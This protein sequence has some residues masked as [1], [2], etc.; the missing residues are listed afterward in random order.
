MKQVITVNGVLEIDGKILLA[1]RAASKQ[2]A[3]GLYHLPGGHVE[4]GEEPA[5]ALVREFAE[6]FEIVVKPGKIIH[7]FSYAHDDTHA[8]GIAYSLTTEA[9]QSTIKPVTDDN[10]KIAWVTASDF[11]RYLDK[12][13]HNYI[14]LKEYFDS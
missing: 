11:A 10:D 7:A 12:N 6:E 9:P 13:D 2:V 3:P 8:V 14:I 4:F 1:R 5:D